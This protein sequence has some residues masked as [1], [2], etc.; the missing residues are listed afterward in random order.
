MEG[1]ISLVLMFV[2]ALALAF[3]ITPRV[4]QLAIKINALDLPGERKLHRHPVPRLGGIAI[5]LAFLIA[6]NIGV[7]LS[8]TLLRLFEHSLRG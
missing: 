6:L 3:V 2:L 4:Q 5:Y 7:L 1:W 8:D